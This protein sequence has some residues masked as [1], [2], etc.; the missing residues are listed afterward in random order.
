MFMAM[1]ISEIITDKGWK[2]DGI[3]VNKYCISETAL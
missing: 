3:V 1:G 2:Q